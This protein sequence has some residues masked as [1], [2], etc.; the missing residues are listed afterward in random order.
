[1]P[2]DGPR[3]TRG[4]DRRDF[5]RHAS[6][7]LLAAGSSSL[8]AACGTAGARQTPESCPSED[9]SASERTLNFSNWPEYIDQ[10]T[11]IVDGRRTSAIPTIAG[12]EAATG[13]RVTYNSDVN[14]NA[15]FFAK[16]RDQLA[17]C[18]PIGR[19]IV[20]LTDWAAARMAALGWLQQLDRSRMPNVEAH[21][22][23]RLRAPAWD[24]QRAFT[25]PWQSG[26]VGLAYNAKYTSAV[27]SVEE[28][29][30]RKDLRGKV[31][32]LNEMNDTLSV[33]LRI[34]G[35]DPERF[36]D[37]DADRALGRLAEI[38]ASGQVRRFT[39]NDFARDLDAGNIAACLAWSGDI[40]AMQES[41]PDIR[42]VVPEEG[43]V[44][45]SDNMLVP[46]RAT[47]KAN[48]ERLMDYYYRPEV[49]ARVTAAVRFIC[50]VEGARAAMERI[51]PTLVDNPLIFPDEAMLAKTFVFMDLPDGKRRRYSRAF[52]KAIGA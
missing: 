38:V 31:S 16:V 47:H 23:P 29:L 34:V 46:N 39:G 42:W 19:D 33:M 52:A 14:D 1:M 11:A 40:L 26:L 50:P 37:A 5:L 7:S 6:L 49:A 22:I 12:F 2:T 20:V 10:G 35:A 30:T 36:D 15:E 51:D 9:L 3:R 18:Q 24:P 43:M 45:F 4:V 21:L 28:M 32:L 27:S 8:L 25:V 48:A 41:N 44:L 13:I 17:A